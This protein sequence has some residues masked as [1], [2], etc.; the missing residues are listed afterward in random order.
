MGYMIAPF[1]IQQLSVQNR[2]TFTFAVKEEKLHKWYK[3]TK[4]KLFGHLRSFILLSSPLKFEI[5][6]SQ[7]IK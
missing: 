6:A 1:Y 5:F 2:I 4:T 7:K 3:S